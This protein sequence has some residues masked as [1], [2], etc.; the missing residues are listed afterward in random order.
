MIFSQRKTVGQK[1]FSAG[2]LFLFLSLLT[3]LLGRRTETT[4]SHFFQELRVSYFS[5][6]YGTSRKVAE[7]AVCD[8][9]RGHVV[10]SEPN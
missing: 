2:P 8:G 3:A 9:N 1:T 4:S 7:A 6:H 5:F 10:L